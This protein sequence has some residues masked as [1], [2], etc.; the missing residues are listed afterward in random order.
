MH[1]ALFAVVAGLAA[2]SLFALWFAATALGSSRH[3]TAVVSTVKYS[4]TLGTR[5]EIP[6]PKG[7][8][9]TA[10]GT[11]TLVLTHT[12]SKYS[13]TW[14]LTYYK[15]T[16]KAIAAHIHSGPP[17]GTGPVIVPLCGPCKSGH[18]GKASVSAKLVAAL[19]AQTAYVNVHT[20]RNPAGEIRGRIYKAA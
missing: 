17:S 3:Q 4:S 19:N 10:G 11:F 14:K 15:L 12:G 1:K 13:V 20:T 16:G 9:P 5:A 8:S 6:K 7:V 2:G 18:S